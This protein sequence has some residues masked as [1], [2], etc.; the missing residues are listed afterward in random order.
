LPDSVFPI[1]SRRFHHAI[2]PLPNEP[3]LPS[4]RRTEGPRGVSWANHQIR[5]DWSAVTRWAGSD[6]G[7]RNLARGI[8][9]A[10]ELLGQDRGEVAA[11]D[12]RR[13]L[14]DRAGA[15]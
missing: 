14:D 4:I 6:G 15:R 3:S 11:V 9:L 12:L 7:W 5:L 2:N 10:R 8:Q 13:T 1:R